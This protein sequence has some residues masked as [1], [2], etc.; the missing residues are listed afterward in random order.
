MAKGR[1]EGKVSIVTGGTIGIG[2]ETAVRMAMEGA[3]VVATGRNEAE[4][5]ETAHIFSRPAATASTSNTT[6]ATKARGLR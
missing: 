6:S 2:R 1:L 3:K 4:G 5:A